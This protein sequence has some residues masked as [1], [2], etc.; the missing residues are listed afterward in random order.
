MRGFLVVNGF[1]RTVKFQE[2][3]SLFMEA[4]KCLHI[5]LVLKK[6]TELYIETGERP[7]FVLFWDK[8]TVLAKRLQNE[9]IPVYNSAKSIALCD[10]K[11]KMYLALKKHG[12]P[13]PETVLAPMTYPGIGYPD[14]S[15]LDEIEKVFPYPFIVK[16][17]C[18]SFGAQVYLVKNRKELESLLTERTGADFLF[19]RFIQES[20]GRDIRLQ[21]VGG[22]V[23][24]SMYR[25][26]ETDFRANLTAG[27]S[28]RGYEPTEEEKSLA[29][30]ASTAVE[31]DFAG[32][33]LLFGRDGP[34]VCEVNSN[35]H[36][37]NLFDCTGVNTAWEILNYIQKRETECRN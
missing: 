23:V 21:V 12:I 33:D 17:G 6:N 5:S 28:M 15:F 14:F 20:K 30:R 7:D 2:L 11:R 1:L 19:Q 34:L 36:F 35:A 25:Y 32:V 10:D 9:G 3:E 24:G 18:G 8:D 29:V 13:M 31:T 27:G 4:A 37:K 26:S 16:E 22:R